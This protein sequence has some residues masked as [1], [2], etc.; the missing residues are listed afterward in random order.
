MTSNK[1]I[2][3]MGEIASPWKTTTNVYPIPM[4]GPESIHTSSIKQT[5]Q[6]I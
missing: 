3:R 6:A 1:G 5:E 2:M 4:V